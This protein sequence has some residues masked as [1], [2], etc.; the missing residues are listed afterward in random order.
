[1][2]NLLLQMMLWLLICVFQGVW[3]PQSEALLDI[4]VVDTDAQSYRD[5]TPLAVLSSAEHDI[6]RKY[7]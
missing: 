1:M 4:C 6:K 3:I 5:C 2:N 7:L